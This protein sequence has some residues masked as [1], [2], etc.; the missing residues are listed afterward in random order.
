MFK[1]NSFSIIIPTRDRAGTL[2]HA[3]NSVR[4][5]NYDNWELIIVDDGSEDDTEQVVRELGGRTPKEIYYSTS[6]EPRRNIVYLKHDEPTERVGAFNTGHKHATKDWICW[7]GSDDEY[8]SIYLDTFN[9]FINENPDFKIFNCGKLVYHYKMTDADNFGIKKEKHFNRMSLMEA[10]EIPAIDNH[11]D[12]GLLGAGMFIFRRDLLN[13]VLPDGQM[14]FGR[15]CYDFADVAGIPGY[16]SK[17]RT[18][19]NPWGEDFFMIYKLTRVA[20]SKKI[21]IPLYIHFIR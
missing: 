12:S 16:S 11:F 10:K 6:H 17:T 7:L 2:K 8:L 15:N 3:I 5:Q 21:D 4:N 14:P 1:E 20:P 19:G 13:E 9:K 18:L